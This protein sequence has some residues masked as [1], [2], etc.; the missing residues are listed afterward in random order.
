MFRRLAVTLLVT[1][2][3]F[4]QSFTKADYAV[5]T[6]PS[7]VVTAD[8]NHDG[9]ADIAV[10]NTGSSSVSI[11]LGR[12]DGTFAG[13]NNIGVA[14]NPTEIVSADLNGDG[15]P[16]LAVATATGVT[17]LYLYAD[18]SH[19]RFDYQ[20]AAQVRSITAA[21]FNGDGKIDL[22]ANVNGTVTILINHYDE[23]FSVS[24]TFTTD[25]P[26]AV[27]RAGD[28]N[29]DGVMDL[30][31]GSCCQGGDVTYGAFYL[32]TG[33]GDGTFSVQKLFDQS[34][35]TKLTVADVTRDGAPDL[36][37]P[38]V[39]C[40]TPCMGIEVEA[41][42]GGTFPRNFGGIGLGTL[43]YSGPGQAA[44]ADFN[45]DG[46]PEVAD[47]FGPADYTTKPGGSGLDKVL[48]WTVGSDGK[49]TNQRDYAIG[50]GYG[51]YGIA[52]GDFNHDGRPDIVVTD[53]R[54]N[55]I[56]VLLN[57]STGTPDFAFNVQFSPQTVKAGDKA[58]YEYTLEALNG[59]L[60][61]VQLSC[62][63]LPQGIACNFQTSDTGNVVLGFLNITTTARTTAA[64]H[65]NGLMTFASVLPFGFVVL[66][67]NRRKRALAIA[68]L[69]VAFALIL[70]TGCAGGVKGGSGTEA[71]G[72]SSTPNTGGTTGSGT[73]TGSGG[74]TTGGGTTGGGTTG[75]GTTGGTTTPP[76]A[77]PTPA[78]SYQVTVTAVAGNVTHSQVI[79]LNVQ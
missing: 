1:A 5:G 50:E 27:I 44:V 39:G 45:L 7:G 70:Q 21:D 76:A 38:Y 65:W 34:D 58:Q 78:G 23:S 6:Q 41:N 42:V 13:A 72:P 61:Q 18:G 59:A 3:C 33:K 11:L 26:A 63:G 46:V 35:G 36:I 30:A 10:A 71:N 73:T 19:T 47:S 31:I 69:L 43:Q 22:A 8:F 25:V 4:A 62:S 60:P 17:I 64:L 32:A 77:G 16:D 12:G 20:T 79:T 14:A 52:V 67:G 2:S 53:Q 56:T 54:I 49:F 74:T 24:S 48:L 28:F 9:V 51:P 15:T 68:V 75:G 29:R 57:N 40:H 37:M 55:K 66:P